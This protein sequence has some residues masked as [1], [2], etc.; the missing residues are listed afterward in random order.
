[1]IPGQK[2]YSGKPDFLIENLICEKPLEI[3]NP[4]IDKNHLSPVI[5]NEQKGKTNVG[6][7]KRPLCLFLKKLKHEHLGRMQLICRFLGITTSHIE[8]PGD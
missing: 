7:N 3:Q 2:S 8:E 5:F 1:M 4:I 6:V